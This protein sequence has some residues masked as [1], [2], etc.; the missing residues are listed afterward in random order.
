MDITDSTTVRDIMATLSEEEVDCVRGAVGASTFD[1]IQ[2]V[3]LSNVSSGIAGFPLECLTPGNAIGISVVFM[4]VEAGGLSAETRDCIR[5][6]AT[7]NPNALR[8]DELTADTADDLIAAIQVHLCLSDE[9][10]AAMASGT[11]A[12]LPPP[13][14]LQCLV[15]QLGGL[16]TLAESLS[17]EA[18]DDMALVLFSA[19]MDCEETSSLVVPG[20]VP[21]GRPLY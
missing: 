16:E 7:E 9:E 12:E 6:V 2:D 11:D 19:A 15:E 1:A 21:S 14:V 4:S 5:D 13:S 20:G 18:D 8:A 3:P 10:Y 17:A